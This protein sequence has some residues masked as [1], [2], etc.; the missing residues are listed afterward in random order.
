M[1]YLERNVRHGLVNMLDVT[2]PAKWELVTDSA[3]LKLPKKRP[4]R[5]LLFIH[6]TFSSTIGGYGRSP[7]PRGGGS[8]CRLHIPTMML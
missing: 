6:G 3:P 2:D 7:P 4:A 5:I 8:F 1:K